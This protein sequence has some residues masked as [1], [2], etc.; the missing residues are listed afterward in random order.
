MSRI[1]DRLLD[2][3]VYLYRSTEEAAASEPKGATGFLV[4][5][6]SEESPGRNYIYAVTANHVVKAENPA[7]VLRLN[8]VGGG[9][10]YLDLSPDDWKSHHNLDDVAITG[11][12]R[13]DWPSL[14]YA[15]IPLR[16]FITDEIIKA[17]EIGCGD[18]VFMVGRFRAHEGRER[19]LPTV[20][21]GNIAMMPKEPV[22]HQ[23]GFKQESFLVETRSLGG[24]SGSPVFLRIPHVS[25][26]PSDRRTPKPKS[27]ADQVLALHGEAGPWLLGID[28][29]HL[30]ITE[31]VRDSQ[32]GDPTPSG[33][34]VRTNSGVM[35]VVPA[36]RLLELLNLPEVV[37]VRD[38]EE[39]EIAETKRRAQIV[40]DSTD[41]DEPRRGAAPE[42]LKIKGPMDKAVKK[43][44]KKGKPPKG[45][46]E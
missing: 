39:R 7:P 35:G 5:V 12:L 44:L 21:F 28:Y 11:P 15:A 14:E 43:M 23:M 27:P 46:A 33:E 22:E 4:G 13:L 10:G 31:M 16:L 42:R 37:A 26:R 32:T 2:S 45:A 38:K 36:W 9:C 30:P 6:P 8:K 34:Y 20:R 3:V 29:G 25:V 40:L 19:N 18:E 17:Q 41:E 24:Y 1:D